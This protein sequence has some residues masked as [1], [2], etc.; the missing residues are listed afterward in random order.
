[1]TPARPPR[2]RRWALWLLFLTALAGAG[3]V[4]AGWVTLGRSVA[5][6]EG[7]IAVG[8]L[9][10]PV[11]I[12]FD[13]HAVPHIYARD[14]EDVWFATGYLHARERLWQM[15]LYRRAAGGRLSEILG[16]TTLRLDKRFVGLGVRRAA[17]EEWQTASAA[18]WSG[19]ARE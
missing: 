12:L 19:T 15:E 8:G 4:I 13:A 6:L 16:P 5:S 7:S 3:L 9:Q 2:R 17:N 14:V 10:A 1:V 18:R 11:E